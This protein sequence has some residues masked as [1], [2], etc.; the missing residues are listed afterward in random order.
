MILVL[1]KFLRPTQWLKNLVLFF[2]PFLGGEFL[3]A[4]VMEK[5]LAPFAAFCLA[6]SSTYVFND[7]C[8]CDNDR[9]HPDKKNR[10]IPSGMVTLTGAYWIAAL[11]LASSLIVAGR[12][13]SG[14]LFLLATYLVLSISY[15]SKLKNIP[16]VDIFCISAGFLLRLLAGGQTFGIEISEWLFLT[17][18]LL[19]VFLS[20]GKRL[21]EKKF[22][23]GIAGSHRKSLLEYPEGFLDGAMYLTGS[24]VL[25]TYTMYAISRHSLIYTVPLC[26]FGLL[27]YIFRVKS[28]QSGDPTE[29]LLMDRSLLTISI[30]WAFMV[31]LSIYSPW[32]IR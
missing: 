18:F 30:L 1:I 2:P 7:I 24:A 4:G 21:A 5:G 6:A 8:D 23:C 25:V 13:S 28:G 12:I 20:T 26:C 19:A 29:S 15:S 17:V 27:R 31:S 3:K 10:P 14:F 9:N 22:L 16:I 11:L 32:I